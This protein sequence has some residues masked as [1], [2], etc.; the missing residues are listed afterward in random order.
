VKRFVKDN[1]GKLKMDEDNK[2]LTEDHL[3]VRLVDNVEMLWS[4]L[5]EFVLILI[6][7]WVPGFN[8]V[9]GFRS[10]GVEEAVIGLYA[11]PWLVVWDELRKWW[12]RYTGNKGIIAVWTVF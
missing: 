10:I 12:I 9:F 11:L 6:L 2:P 1:K 4:I 7:L 3:F 5:F 8:N